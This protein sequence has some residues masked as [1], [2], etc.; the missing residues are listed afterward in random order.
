MC[1]L[2]ITP[3][4]IATVWASWRALLKALRG[5]AL[6][7]F[8][9]EAFEDDIVVHR[10]LGHRQ[11]I[12]NRPDAI[13][14][15][16]VENSGNCIRTAPTIRV[17][18]PVFG[19]GLFLSTGEDWKRQRR[20]TASAFAQ[21]AVRI[22]ARHV[23]A[24]ENSL[25]ADLM[26]SGR[27]QIDLIPVLQRLALEIIGSAM[28]S[29]EMKKH[30]GEMRRLILRYAAHLGRPTLLD[31]VL[32]LEIPTPFDIG[33]RRF[34]RRWIALIERMIDER[35]RRPRHRAQ[36]DLFDLLV[37]DRPEGGA[38]AEQLA[39]QVAT[40]VVAG[41]ETTAAALFW[42]LYLMA[43]V[44]DEQEAVA[45]EAASVDLGPEG[46]AD[47]APQLIRTRAIVEETLRLYPPTFV[48]VRQALAED[49]VD[50]ILVPARS[51]VLVAPWVLH[52]HRRLWDKPEA[53]DPSRFLPG[54]P[55]PARFAYMP[56][57][58]GPRVCIGG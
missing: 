29:L 23:A 8:P 41:H 16:L 55:P 6:A 5:N 35:G 56:F 1:E 39:D 19:C 40:I 13:R 24:A 15:I 52:R 7:T 18:G 58:A 10:F 50:G 2:Q 54:A 21:R 3:P 46:A 45:A 33:R 22:L 12:F 51:L 53:F 4:H 31:F 28:F 47:A 26:A 25:I 36:P 11:L 57:G 20:T 49:L 32:P 9:R 14:R 34:R 43:S 42:S 17:L 30:G 37:A 48:I 38:L 27:S 44:P